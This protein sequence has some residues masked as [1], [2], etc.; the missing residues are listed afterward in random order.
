[1]LNISDV[2]V[3]RHAQ[4]NQLSS[5]LV[6]RQL[7]KPTCRAGKFFWWASCKVLGITAAT[8]GRPSFSWRRGR[9]YVQDDLL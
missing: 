7:W 5:V 8:S 2:V 4:Q 6:W 9:T 3:R 1:M